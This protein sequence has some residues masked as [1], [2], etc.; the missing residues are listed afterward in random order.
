MLEQRI[1]L[2]VSEVSQSGLAGSC[3]YLRL[4]A[5]GFA[6]F[7]AVPFCAEILASICVLM[8]ALSFTGLWSLSRCCMA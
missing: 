3:K 7:V 8:S 5:A 4:A 2:H 1:A 6:A